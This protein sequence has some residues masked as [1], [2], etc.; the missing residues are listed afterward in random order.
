MGVTMGHTSKAPP[1]ALHTVTRQ[2]LVTLAGDNMH[3]QHGVKSQREDRRSSAVP[4]RSSL[5]HS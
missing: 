5:P 4:A 3:A 2:Q 1:L